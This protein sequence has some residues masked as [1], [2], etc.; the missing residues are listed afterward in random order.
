MEKYKSQRNATAAKIKSAHN[1]YVRNIMGDLDQNDSSSQEGGIKHFLGYIKSACK[2]S[3][4]VPT[5]NTNAG[6]V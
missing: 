2:D 5:L 6:P 1:N 3:V 4:G